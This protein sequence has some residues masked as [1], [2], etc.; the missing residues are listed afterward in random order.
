MHTD[1]KKFCEISFFHVVIPTVEI[2]ETK[3]ITVFKS[4][5]ML[6]QLNDPGPDDSIC[7]GKT[8]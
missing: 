8:E 7:N 2:H 3:G 4:R 5:P 6:K 1:N